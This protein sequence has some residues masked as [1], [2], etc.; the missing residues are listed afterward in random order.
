MSIFF[1]ISFVPAYILILFCD[2]LIDYFFGL[3]IAGSDGRVKKMWFLSAIL[4]NLSF[5][6]FFKYFNFFNQSISELVRFFGVTY[7]PFKFY[8][9]VPLGLSFHTFQSVS[10]L[11]EIYRRSYQP[12]KNLGIL[13]LYIL[14]YPQLVSGP[15][16][17][18]Q[19][20][21]PQL[22]Q[23]KE[24]NESN[25]IVGF[26]RILWGF[27][28]KV[29]LADGLGIMVNSVYN[30]PHEF[31]GL[32]LLLATFLFAYQI[33]FDFSGYTDIALGSAKVLGFDL[34]EN[35][36]L[37]YSAKSISEF[38]R[39]WNI[40]LS[41]WMRD[42]IYIPL[43]GSRTSRLRNSINILVTF[44]VS[45][46][47]HGANTTFIIWGLL[48]GVYLVVEKFAKQAGAKLFTKLS[49]CVA[50][51][52]R[53]QK[54]IVFVLVSFAWIF[55]RANN[56]SDAL[57]IVSHLFTNIFKQTQQVFLLGFKSVFSYSPIG[58][59]IIL[60]LV[61]IVQRSEALLIK[62]G[63]VHILDKMP[64]VYRW[65]IYYAIVILIIFLGQSSQQFIYFQF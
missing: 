17:R 10:Y 31:S 24:Y 16:E 8:L 49:R 32:P 55:F 51:Y 40:S 48:H 54:I 25:V 23:P 47:W 2:I 44:F 22:K 1:Y 28:K 20:L 33:Y 15:I 30:H 52:E 43:G 6:C 9:L 35:F 36:K 4:L 13:A 37:P 21:I 58:F 38:W 56:V 34:V 57:Y 41:S 50:V 59:L 60:I 5:L 26:R 11:V 61:F 3:K 7:E 63:Y 12:E 14:F 46:L 53:L 42:Y 64:K 39:R 65:S 45:G 19:E 27:L 18:P 29:V 62:F